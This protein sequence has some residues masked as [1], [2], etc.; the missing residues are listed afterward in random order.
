MRRGELLL[1]GGAAVAL[2]AG[3]E[4]AWWLHARFALDLEGLS[5]LERAG[6]AL[7]DFRPLSTAVFALGAVAVI[8]GT[9]E[10]QARLEPL[11][12]PVQIGVAVLAAA[13]AALACIVVGLAVWIAAA[14][15]IGRPDELGFAYSTEDRAFTLVTQLVAWVPLGGLLTLLALRAT[16]APD[17]G[18]AEEEARPEAPVSEEMEELW[19]DHLAHGPNRERARTLL[20]RIHALEEA[21]DVDGARELAEQMRRLR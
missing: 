10:P 1:L 2:A 4:T 16:A 5:V 14:G 11:V 21:G 13:H 15:E 19:R 7:W 9:A 20:R 17:E 12:A 18:V 3:A 6:A 8:L